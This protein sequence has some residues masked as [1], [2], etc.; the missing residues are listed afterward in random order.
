MYRFAVS[1]AAGVLCFLLL[2]GGNSSGQK[3]KDK[4]DK[5]KAPI[6]K[7]GAYHDHVKKATFAEYKKTEGF[8][9][10]NAAAFKK[11]KD[12]LLERQ[13]GKKVRHTFLSK[14]GHP[15]DCVPIEQQPALRNPLLKGHKIQKKAPA[16]PKALAG[17]MK[18]APGTARGISLFLK[19]GDKDPMGNERYAP[20]GTIPIRRL[21]LS[22]LTRFRTIQDFHRK[23]SRGGMADLRPEGDGATHRYAVGRHTVNNYGGSSWL[24]LWKPV[25]AT[26]NFSLSQ[27]W[28]AGGTPTQTVEAGWQVYPQK[29][30]HNDP[31][32][33]I[34]WTA[35]GYNKT[36]AY[37]LDAPGFVQVNHTFYIGGRWSP[38]STT[39]GTQYGFQCVWYK[40]PSN[41]N[42]WLWLRG[43]GSLT[44]IGYYPRAL[45]GSGQMSKNAVRCTFGGEVTGTNSRQMGSGQKA[46]MGWAQAAFQ[47]EIYYFPTQKTSAWAT[48]SS[49]APDPKC[50][51]SDIHNNSGTAWGTYLYF[52]GPKCP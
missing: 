25:P 35:D 11:M 20:K 41:G 16:L 19:P 48:L 8:K 52:G 17:G 29:Y 2:Q 33:F 26:N 9:A 38:V 14:N 44:A 45:F 46:S 21:T 51:T 7:F 37:N 23:F 12:Y 3:D 22:Q 10:A 6:V 47:K 39:N 50:Y 15:I 34:Y 28:Y 13:K 18:K 24:N 1:A 30:G 4:K 43:T 27:V 49:I 40:D 36:G 31:V 5:D 32:L 42:W